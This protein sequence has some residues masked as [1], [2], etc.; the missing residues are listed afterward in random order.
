MATGQEY[1]HPALDKNVLDVR[2]NDASV[3]RYCRQTDFSVFE[4]D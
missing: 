2:E 4:I 3:Y 1:E